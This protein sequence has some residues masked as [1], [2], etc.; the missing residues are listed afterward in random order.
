MGAI[1]VHT[2]ILPRG[3]DDFLARHTDPRWPRIV[4]EA[5][6]GCALHWGSVRDRGLTEHVFDPVLR[7][8]DLDRL[9]LERQVLSPP[10][11]MFCYWAQPAP[12]AE[13]CRLHNDAMASVV[14][15]HPRRFLG[16]AIV[17]LQAPDLAV[18]EAE[19]AAGLG[20]RCLEIGSSVDG[21]DL[22]DEALVPVWEA[23]D[24][25]DLAL[26]VHPAAP[27]LGLDRVRKYNLPLVLGNPLETALTITRV[28][29]GG[30]LDRW[31]RLR[32]CFAHGGGAFAFVAGRVDRGWS[33]MPEGKAAVPRLPSTYAR[34]IWVDSITHS[35]PALRFIVEAHGP[36]RVVL[37]SDYPF[38]MG[39]D[40]P[41]AALDEAPLDAATRQRI[42]ETNA[43]EFLGL[44]PR[45]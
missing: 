36:E 26:F 41:L 33:V 13:F 17:P 3:W 16:A 22:D 5:G 1:D 44:G 45:P 30:L 39:Y 2:H 40:D 11:L 34:R 38:R 18:K 23:A 21:R 25:L 14:A 27:V 4:Q 10:P 42:V 24:A 6:G 28:I 7:I 31:P 32:W 15:A 35:A 20:F 8:E 29:Y 19:R 9:G 37:G 12:A 43:E